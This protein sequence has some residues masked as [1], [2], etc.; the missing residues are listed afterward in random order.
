MLDEFGYTVVDF[1]IFKSTW[2][3][4][5]LVECDQPTITSLPPTNIPSMLV[6]NNVS[7]AVNNSSAP[8]L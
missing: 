6:L 2:D 1:F 4:Q 8:S 3:F 5:Y 7:S